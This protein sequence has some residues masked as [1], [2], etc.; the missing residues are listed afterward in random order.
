[1]F[2]PARP[3]SLDGL[4]HPAV[5]DWASRGQWLDTT[6]GRL[7]VLDVAASTDAGRALDPLLVLHGFPSSSFDWRHVL[8]PMS[9][10][11]RVILFD[12]LGFGLSDKPD[13]RYGLRLYA[14]NAEAVVAALEV[15]RLA[16]VTHDIGDSVGGELLRRS[17]EGTLAFE[18]TRRVITN[19]SIY[20]D[21]AQLTSGQESLLS[22]DDA[23]FDVAAIGLDPAAAFQRGLAGTFA[24]GH[25]PSPDELDAQWQLAAFLGGNTLLPRTIRYIEDRRLEEE[26]Y[27]GAIETH[28]SPLAIVWGE[29]DPVARY[30]MTARLV[31]R[32]PGT[33]LTT[34]DGVGHYPMVE[35]P[36]RFAAA[37]A[38]GLA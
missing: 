29:V 18:I 7:F 30:P 34:L 31:E 9:A 33:P 38:A 22:L 21:L 1:M 28:P 36:T 2:E 25:Q 16:M 14:D 23:P 19:G 3:P 8:D 13:R 15:D 27:T 11:R 24:D 4:T 37:V 20:L 17:L 32:R 12:F 26:R 6:Q 35:D 5:L 10:G